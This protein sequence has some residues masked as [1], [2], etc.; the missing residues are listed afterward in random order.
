MA[1]RMKIAAAAV[2]P[3]P[4][5]CFALSTGAM[6][7]SKDI[8]ADELADPAPKLRKPC[9]HGNRRQAVGEIHLNLFSH[10]DDVEYARG[11]RKHRRRAD[12]TT[13]WQCFNYA[14]PYRTNLIDGKDMFGGLFTAL[15][16]NSAVDNAWQQFDID[17]NGHMSFP[18]FVEWATAALELPLGMDSAGAGEEIACQVPGCGC[19]QFEERLSHKTVCTKCRHKK[20]SHEQLGGRESWDTIAAP[21]CS[22][23]SKEQSTAAISGCSAAG[24]RF[25][26]CG[27]EVVN[28]M[29]KVVDGSYVDVWTCGRRDCEAERA[30]AGG[31]CGKPPKGKV[32][33]GYVVL[34]VQRVESVRL[35]RR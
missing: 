32:P 2:T 14:D 8:L 18:E 20:H 13:L 12:L 17:G 21:P 22:W 7:R 6:P 30:E 28:F 1:R 24:T 27:P 31:G 26:D 9:V 4:E 16:L 35:W 15:G 23:E 29:Q 33:K 10:P 11:V 19:K 3:K 5:A 25:V 34:R